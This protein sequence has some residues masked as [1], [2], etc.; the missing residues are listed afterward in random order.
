M[1][2]TQEQIQ[3]SALEQFLQLNFAEVT[4]KTFNNQGIMTFDY[5]NSTKYKSEEAAKAVRKS[6]KD[7]ISPIVEDWAAETFGPTFTK[8]FLVESYGNGK[9]FL[10]F[11]FPIKLSEAYQRKAQ[12]QKDLNLALEERQA[13]ESMQLSSV[14]EQG[15]LDLIDMLSKRD[16]HA[17]KIYDTYGYQ[18]ESL[19]DYLNSLEEDDYDA[20]IDNP[21]QIVVQPSYEDYVLHKQELVKK[22]EKTIS[23]LYNEKRINNTPHINQKITRFNNIKESLEKDIHDFTKTS[24]KLAITKDFFD[25]DFALIQDLLADPTLENIFLAKDL[26]N[27]IKNS[28]DNRISNI[29]NKLFKPSPN[30]KLEEPVNELIKELNSKINF[31]ERD[32]ELAVD[33]VFLDLLE[34]NENSLQKLYP[35][36]SLEEIKDELLKNLQDISWIESR[37]FTQGEQI[38][39]GN[40]IIE[41]L[42]KLEYRKEILRQSAKSQKFIQEIDALLPGVEKELE[43]LGKKKTSKLG[44]IYYKGFDYR[45]LYQKDA[46]G[47]YKSSLIGK[48]SL[49][50]EKYIAKLNKDYNKQIFTARQNKDWAEVERLLQNK[51]I[52]LNDK[53]DFVNFTLLH[54]IYT[55]GKYSE[56][57]TGNSQQAEEYKQ[58]IINQIGQEEYENLI[59][60]QRNLLDNYIQEVA[61]LTEY[62]LLQE[63]VDSVDDLSESSKAGLNIA[64]K[65]LNPLTFLE[66]YFAGKKGMIEYSIGTQMNEKPSFM[67]YNTFIP[68]PKNNLGIDTNF[69]DTEFGNIETNPTLYEFWKVMRQSTH[70]INENL[71]DSNLRLNGNSLLLMK[72]QFAEQTLDKDSKEIAKEGLGRMTNLKQFI[73]NVISAKPS[74]F[75]TQDEVLLPTEIKSFETEV[76]NEFKLMLTD[77][78]NILGKQAALNTVIRYDTLSS[79]QQKE[80]AELMGFSNVTDFETEMLTDETGNIDKTA[81]QVHELKQF[82]QRKI[83]SQQ[84]LDTPMMI[85]AFLELSSEHKARTKA[86]NE[87]NVYRE[88]S[89][90]ILNERNSMFSKQGEQRENELKRQKYFYDKVV[91]NKNEQDHFGNLS[92]ALIKLTNRNEINAPLVGRIFYKN[93][94]TEEKAIYDSAM[95]RLDTIENELPTAKTDAQK[96]S[97]IEEKLDLEARIRILGKD[98]LFSALFDSVINKL[99][100]QVGL[101][102]NFLANIKNRIQGFTAVLARDGEFWAKG[103]IYPVN[104]FVGLNKTRFVNPAYKEEWDKAVLFI[105]QLNLIQDTTNELQR[106]ESKIKQK[107]RIFSPM[108]GTEVIE[109]YNQVPGI[110]AMAMDLHITDVNGVV[111]PLFDGSSFTAYNNNDG[112]LEL[113]PEFRTPENIQHYEQMDSEDIISW[114]VGV[115]DMINSLNGDYSKTGV[116]LSKSKIYTKPFMIFKTWLP[117]YLHS[118]YR[119][120]QKNIATGETETGFLVASFLNKKTSVA[121]GLMLGV[122]GILGILSTSPAIIALPLFLGVAGAGLAKAHLIK[123]KRRGL[124]IDNTEPI[125]IQQQALYVLKML[126]PD[127]LL[128]APLNTIAGRELIKPVEFSPQHNLTPQEQKDIRLMMRNLQNTIVL[129]MIKVAIQALMAD[130]EEDEPKGEV[131]SEQRARYMAQKLRREEIKAEHNFVEN[132]LTGMLHETSLA[133]EPKSL[134]STMGSKNGLEGPLDKI[135]KSSTLLARYGYGQDEI[136]RG[137][138]IGQSKLGN[139]LR[140]TFLPSLFR[141]I[142]HDTWRG[143]FEQS[144]EKE[145]IN[146]EMIDGMFDSD[147]KEDVKAAKK[148]REQAKLDYIEDFEEKN[149]IDI[150]DVDLATKE[151]IEKEAKKVAKKKSPNPDRKDYN[152]K[153]EKK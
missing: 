82:A 24:D 18:Y 76:N 129:M 29:N 96:K 87:I 123:Q 10:K 125:A 35:G 103:N 132:L 48:F 73:K 20:M 68:K 122:T 53:T 117:K 7:K 62:K 107:A 113:K 80:I 133:V 16:E 41:D 46:K 77:L 59:E 74:K 139:S 19:D 81:F 42:L 148:G 124:I 22:L 110:L 138:R 6:I 142:G 93:F 44:S 36:K 140:K 31:Q 131:G 50:W 108:Y 104:H 23:K 149:K 116:T 30:T 105:K 94:S 32:I 54:D 69:Y 86:Q 100:V 27:Y 4:S 71:I 56:F 70:L 84:T 106:A 21:N 109:Y 78:A 65:R 114:K 89:A 2:C 98:Y 150:E 152:E 146:N 39:S 13:L 64:I 11:N 144:M 60:N 8:G 15:R 57:K 52:E 83:M 49:A 38:L 25:K 67:K 88:K 34:K 128:E 118:R 33:K 127:K 45:F 92:K 85:K 17:H 126:R 151:K 145:W 5:A 79:N 121:G 75:T 55:D 130:N 97:L 1:A 72:K 99:S 115:G 26:F 43:S 90:T 134:I 9:V 61:L 91:L 153:Q 14:K 63:N 141:D 111:H 66:S 137:D 37:F 136:S 101:G 143:G 119:I 95:K 102:Y 147:Y 47:N 51:F 135:V 120:E 3:Q 28:A 112:V 12:Y 40:N 58:N